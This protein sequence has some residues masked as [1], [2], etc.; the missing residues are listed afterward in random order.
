MPILLRS[1]RDGVC[2]LTLNRPEPRNAINLEMLEAFGAALAELGPDVRCVVLTGS[3]NAFCAGGDVR[4]MAQRQG[5]ALETMQ[6][7]R[8]GLAGV[9]GRIRASDAPFL[10]KVNGDCIGAGLGLALACD[11]A[12]ASATA[13]FGAPF[14]SLGLVP[15]TALTWELPRRMG[16]ARAKEFVL[17][18][19]LLQATEAWELGLVNKV[20]PA[21]DLDDEVAAL[22]QRL[23]GVPAGSL[24]TAKRALQR[25]AE[26]GHEEAMLFEAYEQGLRFTSP[27][28]AAGVR[29]F[30]ERRKG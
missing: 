25:G 5:Q 29:A 22:A 23:S 17:T 30:G 7:I 10:A 1:D 15:D 13:R 21:P 3:G 26:L 14:A 19:T 27:E 18:G 16:L 28:H 6:R 20:V 8:S 4:E 11:I 12:Y 2:T 24:G 9:V